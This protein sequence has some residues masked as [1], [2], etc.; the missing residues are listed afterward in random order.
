MV[1]DALKMAGRSRGG[2]AG[3]TRHSL[4]RQDTAQFTSVRFTERLDE[5]RARPSIGTVA[6]SFDKTPSL[7]RPTAC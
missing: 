4:R 1:L 2:R 5:I 7:R 3:P 6:D